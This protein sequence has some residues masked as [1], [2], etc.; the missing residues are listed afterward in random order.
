MQKIFSIILILYYG[1]LTAGTGLSQEDVK[2]MKVVE[3]VGDSIT[4][5][6]GKIHGV[7]KDAVYDIQQVSP[8]RIKHIGIA[9]VTE[10]ND[11]TCALK[12]YSAGKNKIIVGDFLVLNETATNSLRQ[13]QKSEFWVNVQDQS[14]KSD[15]LIL[16]D[17]KSYQNARIKFSSGKIIK[18]KTIIVK[19]TD[20][21][22]LPSPLRMQPE[23]LS[24]NDITEIKIPTKRYT[25]QGSLVG[26]ALTGAIVLIDEIKNKP[27]EQI[28]YEIVYNKDEY[29]KLIPTVTRK[30]RKIDNR[31]SATLRV[32]IVGGG[33]V[34]GGFLGSLVK[35][36]WKTIYPTAHADEKFSYGI[37][38][39]N[40][41]L[42]YPVFSF[43]YRF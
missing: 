32:V 11:T 8:D 9:I 27:Q 17:G 33:F 34:V 43:Y 2:E 19:G 42:K 36:G 1:I 22:L 4:A 14:M 40:T 3:V 25:P 12:A 38:Y 18:G 13:A 5:N 6:M 41:S 29:G 15:D 16:S 39:L 35:G 26:I 37:S 30:I 28:Y 7:I 24:L 10:I 31:I 21:L 20:E 23:I